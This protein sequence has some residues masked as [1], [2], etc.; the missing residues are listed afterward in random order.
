M[1]ERGEL[2]KTGKEQPSSDRRLFS[3][4]L[5]FGVVTLFFGFFQI[6]NS[7]R[8]PFRLPSNTNEAK[9]GETGSEI[10]ALKKKDTDSDGL[11]DF[12]ELYTY[13]TSP[14]LADSDSDS[15][16]DQ[17][18]VFSGTDPNCAQGTTCSSLE[19]ATNA[20][21]ASTNGATTNGAASNIQSGLPINSS[22]AS[23]IS[24]DDLRIALRNAGAPAAT[25]EGMSDEQL[26]Q[27]YQEVV[28][29][30][31]TNTSIFTN[32]GT[33]ASSANGA[34]TNVNPASNIN[35][36]SSVDLSTLQS[37]TPDQIRAFLKQGGAD[38]QLLQQVD[39]ETLRSI[40][41]DALKGSPPSS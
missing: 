6:L 5:L 39:D 13:Q 11:S 9:L 32:T 20:N 35:V 23:D 26:L 4:L 31:D 25:L 16:A 30:T 27:L 33:N 15:L 3:V 22:T 17:Q 19:L 40:F 28:G 41:L 14:Y 29:G 7:I 10:S 8:G 2:P 38:D 21:A 24:L 18:E 1:D 12:D 34:T 36:N 37:L